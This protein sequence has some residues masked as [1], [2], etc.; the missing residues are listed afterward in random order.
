[1]NETLKSLVKDLIEGDPKAFN[2]IYR[3]YYLRLFNFANSYCRNHFVAE[4]IV[5]DTF[6]SLWD[7]REKIEL[8]INLPGYLLTMVKNKSLNHLQ[9]LKVQVKAEEQIQNNIMRE[10]GLRETLLTA[11]NPEE[12]FRSD[13]QRIIKETLDTVSPQCRRVF[14]MSRFDGLSN[15][16]IASQLNISVKGVEF[17]ITKGLKA[18]RKNLKDYLSLFVFLL[19]RSLF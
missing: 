17:Q 15:K 3:S 18:L 19:I 14:S 12:M 8:Q 10:L 16:Q 9:H 5:Q 2:S 13:V 1:M 6:T 7:M 4:N 11:C